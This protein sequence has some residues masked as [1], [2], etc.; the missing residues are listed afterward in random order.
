MT[1]L[2]HIVSRYSYSD[3]ALPGFEVIKLPFAEATRYE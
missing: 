3:A 1:L 2:M